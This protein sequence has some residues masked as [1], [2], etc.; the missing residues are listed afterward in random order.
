MRRLLLVLL[1]CLPLCGCRFDQEREPT[2]VVQQAPEIPLPE[3]PVLEKMTPEE[4]VEYQ[5]LPAPVR[6]KL[7]ANNGKLQTYAKELEVSVHI[8]NSYALRNNAVSRTWL[9]GGATDLPPEKK[10]GVK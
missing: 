2:P 4:L 1:L 8:Y 9:R 10:E 7:E 3:R 5:K 6:A